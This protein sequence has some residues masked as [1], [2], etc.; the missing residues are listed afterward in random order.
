M[1]KY[2]SLKSAF[3]RFLIS[4]TV[5]RLFRYPD[6]AFASLD[7][8]GKGYVE[9]GDVINHPLVYSTPL[10]KQEVSEFCETRVFTGRQKHMTME[11]F[12]KFFYPNTKQKQVDSDSE[13]DGTGVTGPGMP[14]QLSSSLKTYQGRSSRSTNAEKDEALADDRASNGQSPQR[15]G[16]KNAV[17]MQNLL[18]LEHNLK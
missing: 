13:E 3:F 7:F 14:G 17:M 2:A 4:S 12:R 18:E 1:A 10:N 9:A 5:S 11:L 16:K 8:T 15:S 6:Q